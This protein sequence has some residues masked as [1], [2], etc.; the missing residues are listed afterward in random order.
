MSEID[1]IQWLAENI[2]N[3]KSAITQ[4]II[5]GGVVQYTLNSGQGS[6]SVRRATLAELNKQLREFQ[7]LY[8]EAKENYTGSNINVM[9]SYNNAH[10]PFGY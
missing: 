3:I 5:S 1:D 2:K 9:R 7:Y 6:T 4:A 10:Q 8:N